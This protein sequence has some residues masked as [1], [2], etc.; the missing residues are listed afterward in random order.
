MQGEVA[1]S[2]ECAVGWEGLELAG[3]TGD[4]QLAVVVDLD[5]L[6]STRVLDLGVVEIGLCDD[7]N[8]IAHSLDDDF[9]S[10]ED[11]IASLK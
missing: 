4:F 6:L 10:A 1:V 7:S 9:R 3:Q 8:F 11:P 5:E 2:G